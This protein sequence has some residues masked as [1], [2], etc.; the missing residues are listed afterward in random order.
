[1]LTPNTSRRSF[2]AAIISAGS[3]K[4]LILIPF[5]SETVLPVSLVLSG[6]GTIVAATSAVANTLISWFL[7][8]RV[9]AVA[10]TLLS[11]LTRLN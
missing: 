4:L 5:A 10:S 11:A 6:V 9:S 3:V 2:T 1:M 7:S 8:K